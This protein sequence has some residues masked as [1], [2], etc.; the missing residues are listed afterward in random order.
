MNANGITYWVLNRGGL[1]AIIAAMWML[2]TGC[3]GDGGYLPQEQIASNTHNGTAASVSSFQVIEQ[4]DNLAGPTGF[5]PGDTS[6]FFGSSLTR[7]F[8]N[9]W[10]LTNSR[11]QPGLTGNFG[12]YLIYDTSNPIVANYICQSMPLLCEIDYHFSAAPSFDPSRYA[13]VFEAYRANVRLDLYYGDRLR[14]SRYRN[15][16]T[17]LAHGSYHFWVTGRTPGSIPATTDFSVHFDAWIEHST[18]SILGEWQFV[19]AGIEVND[20]GISI[21]VPV[22]TGRQVL[23]RGEVK[24]WPRQF[25]QPLSSTFTLAHSCVPPDLEI[26]LIL[27]GQGAVTWEMESRPGNL[28]RYSDTSMKNENAGRI[29]CEYNAID[30]KTLA[31]EEPRDLVGPGDPLCEEQ[32]GIPC[33]SPLSGTS[34]DSLTT[35]EELK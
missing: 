16:T 4:T 33:L 14:P 3:D 34:N 22:Q 15:H 25:T 35:L 6:K 1:L 21:P 32:D 9:G 7:T 28:T 26:Y 11:W 20:V 30:G 18:T 12:S 8:L 5:S 27:Y 24:R 23:R 2:T 31:P 13:D 10:G 19:D 17:Q 29:P